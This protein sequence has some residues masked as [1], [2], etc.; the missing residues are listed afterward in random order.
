VDQG[1]QHKTRYNG[2]I[3]EKVANSLEHISSG[4]FSG[5]RINILLPE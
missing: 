4:N 2:L 5:N 3:E 1:P